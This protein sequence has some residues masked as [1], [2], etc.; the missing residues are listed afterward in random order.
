MD[1][2]DQGGNFDHRMT[3]RV[4]FFSDAVFA[5]VLTLLVLELHAPGPLSDGDLAVALAELAPKFVAFAGTFVVV[6]IFWAA[7][8]AITRRAQVFDWPF[9]WVNAIYLLTIAITPFAS[10]LIGEN[11]TF[12]LAWRFY[13]VVLIAASIAQLLLLLTLARGGGRLMGGIS[14]R[15]LIWRVLRAVSPGIAF[16]IGL[17]LSLRGEAR[18]SALCWALIP[19]FL[20]AAQALAPPKLKT[21]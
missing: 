19:P 12:G 5:I 1:S 9:L 16:G 6:V 18:L 2:N 7:H 17:Y 8:M 11:G 4:L 13:C 10:A 14:M 3:S 20:L 15:E 21:K